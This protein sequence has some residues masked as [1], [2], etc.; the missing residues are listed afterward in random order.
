VAAPYDVVTPTALAIRSDVDNLVIEVAA[1]AAVRGRVTRHGQPVANVQVQLLPGSAAAPADSE[2]RYVLEGLPAGSFDLYAADPQAFTRRPVTLVAGEAQDIDLELESGGEVL[3]TVVDRAGDPVVGVRVQLMSPGD[4]C[5]SF[6]DAHGGFDCATLAGHRDYDVSVSPGSGEGV[7]EPAAGG[8][9]SAIHVDDGDTVVRDVRL[10][11]DHEEL[12]IRGKVVD[13]TGATVPDARVTVGDSNN[14]GDASRTRA[15]DD[16]GFIIEGLTPGR[17]DLRARMA[18]GSVGDA[19]RVAAGTTGVTITLVRPGTIEGSLVGFSTAP[20]V[21][22]AIG[23]WTEQ[24]VHE[25]KIIGDRF[26]IT[27]L[28]PATYMVQA[29]VD[30]VQIDGTTTDVRTNATAQVTLHGRPRATLEGRV[31]ELGTVVP[32]AKMVCHASLA[33]DQR[34][35]VSVGPAPAPQ[36]TDASGHF[37]LD[38]PVG[39]TR[40][41]CDTGDPAYSSA[42]GNVD[43]PATGGARI[44]VDAVKTMPPQSNPRFVFD[45][46]LIPPTVLRATSSSPVIAGDVAVAVDGV[47][48]SNLGAD[49]AQ[50]LVTN[51]RPGTT[52]TLSLLRGGQPLV[53]RITLN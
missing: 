36:M 17:Y 24:D 4:E 27:G 29:L 28:K 50:T 35:G 48:V 51:H 46:A 39:R 16:G 45:P 31:V 40:V 9:F 1:K 5:N 34:A 26:T 8:Q 10:A 44:E 33:L 42:G 19:K 37:T 53:L 49:A 13:D 41:T 18:D 15:G 23:T 7:Y 52:A 22:A 25:A 2:G 12:A 30:G 43:V 11:I 38:A 47:D 3:G 21:I 14:W 6:T 32:V 20:M